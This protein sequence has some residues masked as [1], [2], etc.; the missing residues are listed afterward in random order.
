[1]GYCLKGLPKYQAPLRTLRKVQRQVK[2]ADVH[3]LAEQGL[4][5]FIDDLQ[6]GLSNV[7]NS[8]NRTYFT[9][10]I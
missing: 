6:L 3:A 4:H 7:H 8:I 1:M 5:E 9:V 10:A 2:E